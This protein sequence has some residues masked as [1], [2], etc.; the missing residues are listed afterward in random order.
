MEGNWDSGLLKSIFDKHPNHFI[1]YNTKENLATHRAIVVV[2]GC[3]EVKQLRSYLET[4]RD[5]V[6]IL[7]SEEDAFFRWEEAVP[8]HLQIWTQYYYEPTKYAIKERILLGAPNRI[9][10]Y[11]INTHLPKI[12][13]WSFIGQVQNPFRQQCVETLSKL[14][15]G[16]LHTTDFF[17]GEGDTGIKYQDYLDILCQ[18]KFVICP[19][20]SMCCDSFRV[21]EAIECG[22]IPITDVRSPRDNEDFNYWQETYPSNELNYMIAG[23]DEKLL[24][25]MLEK[26]YKPAPQHWWDS[27]K[28]ELE[29]KLLNI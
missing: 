21:Y 5:G 18:S 14:Q 20:G 8:N 29:N 24:S 2:V 4:I 17:G 25:W 7:T 10:N 3:P 27:Y 1:Q 26:N 19:A 23:W 13:D 12:Y 11:K 16:Y 15:N 6:V 22:A 28:Q 9:K